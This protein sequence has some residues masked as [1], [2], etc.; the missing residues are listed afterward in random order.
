MKYGGRLY[1]RALPGMVVQEVGRQG[2]RYLKRI[3]KDRVRRGA[4]R[5]VSSVA[6][7]VAPLRAQQ[8]V[9]K[10]APY[11]YRGHMGG[12]VPR[13]M[14]SGIS[15]FER[16][17]AV[18]EWEHGQTNQSS[19]CVYA[20]HGVGVQTVV[21][22]VFCSIIRKALL[23][24]GLCLKG[25][26]NAGITG[27]NADKFQFWL[28][29]KSSP[30]GAVSN[31]T[32][33][34]VNGLATGASLAEAAANCLMSQYG[35]SFNYFEIVEIRV[36]WY[37]NPTGVPAD[38]D[39]R[40]EYRRMADE[41]VFDINVYS[42]LSVQN[43]T[44]AA[45]GAADETNALD[46]AN[47]P[48]YGRVYEGVGTVLSV[49]A[50]DG[51]NNPFLKLNKDYGFDTESGAAVD[52]PAGIGKPPM[53]HAFTRCYKSSPIAISPGQIR[54]SVLSY[55]KRVTLTKFVFM[56]SNYLRSGVSL[57]ASTSDTQNWFPNRMIGLE[58]KLDTRTSEPDVILGFEVNQKV[59]VYCNDYRK[60]SP[61]RLLFETAS[62]P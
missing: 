56:V 59:M 40:E 36:V 6:S 31:A 34:L 28:Q 11:T 45:T 35:V 60:A 12:R 4:Q 2:A 7:S 21:H 19:K 62:P 14:S 8:R 23:K 47:N 20:A 51:V 30:D 3:I 16:S 57:A 13:P 10:L 48:V 53:H 39:Y 24:F 27:S 54:D 32:S 43:R 49:K 29:F 18:I 37:R 1:T 52:V 5:V 46:V 61:L 25:W 41:L 22:A 55:R 42:K 17:G 33:V 58:R 26:Q 15:K 38:D 44:P 9:M 50:Q